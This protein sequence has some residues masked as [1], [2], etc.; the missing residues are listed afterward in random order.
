MTVSDVIVAPCP[1]IID[2]RCEGVNGAHNQGENLPVYDT[3][4]G[5]CTHYPCPQRK[6][7]T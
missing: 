7:G 3:A 2:V 6:S 1:S 5:E 4:P